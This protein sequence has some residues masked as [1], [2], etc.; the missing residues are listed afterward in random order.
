VVLAVLIV[1]LATRPDAQAVPTTTSLGGRIAPPVAGR[2][3]LT[4]API[5]L[6][7]LRGRY[8]VLD[9]FASWC[10]PC[11]AE[12]PQIEAF[13]FAHR[14]SRSVTLVG[15]DIE[16]SVGNAQRFLRHY[17]ATW[18]ALVDTTNAIAQSYG[19]AEPPEVFLIDPKGLVVSSISAAV[20]AGELDTWLG[21]AE[22]ARA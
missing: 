17:G 3:V 9:F 22:E 21:E 7:A 18:P 14:D 5:N 8:V 13:A 11:L 12:E 4:G 15:I 6:R 19:V 10:G 1:V 2:N 20:T 16:D